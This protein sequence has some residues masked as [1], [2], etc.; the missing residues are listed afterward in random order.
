MLTLLL[1][2]AQMPADDEA[3]RE[4][5]RRRGE[6]VREALIAQGVPGERVQVGEARLS[7][8]GGETR[9]GVELD[10]SVR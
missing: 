1:L 5:A 8:D 3:M 9:P 6:A 2:L 4:L 7:G 10:L